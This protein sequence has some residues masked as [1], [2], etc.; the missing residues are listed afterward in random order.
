MDPNL[1]DPPAQAEAIVK[2]VRQNLSKFRAKIKLVNGYK[3]LLQ[4][5][6]EECPNGELAELLAPP[7][8]QR[9][10]GLIQE[11]ALTRALV[12]VL[13]SNQAKAVEQQKTKYA[14]LLPYELTN[15]K[16]EEVNQIAAGLY[17]GFREKFDVGKSMAL[18]YRE[19]NKSGLNLTKAPRPTRPVEMPVQTPKPKK[20]EA[21]SL[22]SDQELLYG[23]PLVPFKKL[24]YAEQT[25]GTFCYKASSDSYVLEGKTIRVGDRVDEA[26]VYRYA[27]TVHLDEDHWIS[28]AEGGDGRIG[29]RIE[30]FESYRLERLPLSSI[31]IGE[32]DVDEE[33]VD[34]YAKLET[35]FPPIIYDPKRKSIIDGAHRCNAA[36]QKGHDSILAFVGEEPRSK[37]AARKDVP[38]GFYILTTG[39]DPV[40][41][42]ITIGNEAWM[43]QSEGGERLATGFIEKVRGPF[44]TVHTEAEHGYGPSLYDAALILATQQGKWVVPAA[45]SKILAGGEV[46]TSEEAEA[47]WKHYYTNRPDVKKHDI[48]EIVPVFADKP[49]L[50]TAYQLKGK[51]EDI[52]PVW[53]DQA[54]TA[55]LK[56][57]KGSPIRRSRLGVGKEIGGDLYLHRNYE[58]L[59][60]D[61]IALE[62]NKEALDDFDYNVVK[63]RKDG[64]MTFFRSPDFDTAD[65]PTAG[66]YIKVSPDGAA[67]TTSRTNAI[68]HHKW[69][70]VGDDY[71]GFDVAASKQR[72][73]DWLALPDIDFSRIGNR[74]FW[75]ENVVPRIKTA[76]TTPTSTLLRRKGVR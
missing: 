54:V 23:S 7:I 60:P 30:A 22:F 44:W 48:S 72:S 27:R 57:Q 76:S 65:E 10:Q 73:R 3:T 39:D 31:N 59:I 63:V 52:G 34:I 36:K 18:T 75:E 35:Q 1:L 58:S 4:Q 37:S 38:S 15:Y 32:W 6:R 41:V 11:S 8:V 51:L 46:S 55:S 66:D 70:F 69:L 62:T 5:L 21:P 24:T 45:A 68:W 29:A 61:Q 74:K 20:Q 49:W 17:A 26:Q 47:V 53:H 12:I 14:T 33:M 19:L 56:T 28:E 42:G 64:S 43:T 25:P 16:D 13:K 71:T 2:Y 40:S 50:S 9:V 67:S